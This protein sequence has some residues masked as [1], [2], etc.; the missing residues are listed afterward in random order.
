MIKG[1]G[2]LRGKEDWGM[3]VR[4]EGVSSRGRRVEGDRRGLRGI[5]GERYR[6]DLNFVSYYFSSLERS[7]WIDRSGGSTGSTWKWWTPRSEGSSWRSWSGR[8]SGRC[9][10]SWSVWATRRSLLCFCEHVK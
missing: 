6:E 4:E 5:E 2:E 9:R 7:C 3:G 8:H 1:E 10:R